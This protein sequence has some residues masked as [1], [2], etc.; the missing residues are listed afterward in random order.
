MSAYTPANLYHMANRPGR[1]E[2]FS[3]SYINP[4]LSVPSVKQRP[5][6]TVWLRPSETSDM[7]KGTTP[8]TGPSIGP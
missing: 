2:N 7:E 6:S 4:R 8:F 1:L 5:T 3:S